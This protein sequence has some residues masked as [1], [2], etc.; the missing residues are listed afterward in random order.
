MFQI[1]LFHASQR[2]FEFI[3][4]F[5]TFNFPFTT[6]STLRYGNRGK[7]ERKYNE[8]IDVY[9]VFSMIQYL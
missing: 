8:G 9:C 7:G 3:A 6:H 5:E 2:R 4:E 1:S